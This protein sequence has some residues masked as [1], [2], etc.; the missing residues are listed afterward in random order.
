MPKVLFY[1]FIHK[2]AKCKILIAFRI[3]F[4]NAYFI[5]LRICAIFSACQ[6]LIKK[7]FDLSS[8]F[9]C[10]ELGGLY[11][12]LVS[13]WLHLLGLQYR[14]LVSDWLELLGLTGSIPAAATTAVK[15]VGP[16]SKL[17]P[18]P[19]NQVSG[20]HIYILY[21]YLKEKTFSITSQG[22][23]GFNVS[24]GSKGSTQY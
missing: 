7:K 10:L 18:N 9:S 1:P 16:G 13:D 14:R 6:F 4:K 24:T 23:I 2:K 17:G 8:N 20:S 22:S 11:R 19:S 12:R 3:L 5:S 15:Q 21:N